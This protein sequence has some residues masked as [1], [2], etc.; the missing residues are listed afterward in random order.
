MLPTA[1]QISKYKI[2]D[3]P[4]YTTYPPGGKFILLLAIKPILK[5]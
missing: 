2:T 1:E 3:T 4:Y 5:I